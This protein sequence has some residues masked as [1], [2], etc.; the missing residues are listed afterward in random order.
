MRK[1]KVKHFG[2]QE[3]LDVFVDKSLARRKSLSI[4]PTTNGF[5]V[6]Y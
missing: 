4:Q 3:T 5:L 1:I 6:H 2:S